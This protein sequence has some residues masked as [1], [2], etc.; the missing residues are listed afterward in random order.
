M[1]PKAPLHRNFAV[2]NRRPMAPFAPLT[3]LLSAET[4]T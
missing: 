3:V 2:L 4:L 1:Q